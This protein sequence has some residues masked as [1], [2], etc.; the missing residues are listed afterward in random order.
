MITAPLNRIM[1]L[2]RWSIQTS[3]CESDFDLLLSRVVVRITRAACRRCTVNSLE[4]VTAAD[5]LK[6]MDASID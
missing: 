3:V 6:V 4:Q 2:S 1:L 5:K